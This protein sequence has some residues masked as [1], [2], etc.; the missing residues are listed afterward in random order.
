MLKSEE[1]WKNWRFK[2]IKKTV[3]HCRRRIKKNTHDSNHFGKI[4]HEK[5]T[6]PQ[7]ML[8]KMKKQQEIS[9]FSLSPSS[10]PKIVDRFFTGVFRKNDDLNFNRK[11]RKGNPRLLP[12][13]SSWDE[14][15]NRFTMTGGHVSQNLCII[16][17]LLC[18]LVPTTYSGTQIIGRSWS[19]RIMSLRKF[20]T[21][22]SYDWPSFTV[23]VETVWR[24]M[25]EEKV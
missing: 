3:Y 18:L 14:A 1:R 4:A 5:S 17:F 23:F 22:P 6:V 25:W 15:I 20:L 16:P 24:R 11:K 21:E 12:K 10:F 8:I 9:S 7:N 2:R 13:H 19:Y